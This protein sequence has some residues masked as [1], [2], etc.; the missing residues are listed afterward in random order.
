MRLV[1][2]AFDISG[3]F[4]AADNRGRGDNGVCTSVFLS[5]TVLRMLNYRAFLA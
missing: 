1:P 4:R 5:T 2:D 3:R